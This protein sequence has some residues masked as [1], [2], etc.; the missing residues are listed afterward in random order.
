[1]DMTIAPSRILVPVDFSA[2]SAAALKMAYR[3]A[4]RFGA[5]IH[6][7]NATVVPPVVE[8]G[9]AVK[10]A[11]HR[12]STTLQALA[13]SS[14]REDLAALMKAH[15]AP[16]GIE[17]THEVQYGLPLEVI[18]FHARQHDLVVVGTHG[19]TGL[20]HLF[21]G[22][23]AERVVRHIDRPVIVARTSTNGIRQVL[24]AVDF[25]N[26]SRAAFVFGR[27]LAQRFGAEAR[28]VHVVPSIPALERAELMVVGAGDEPMVALHDYARWRAHEELQHFLSSMTGC[29]D[30]A[31]EVRF[32]DPALEIIEAAQTTAA[33]IVV[34]G[35]HGHTNWAWV[36][37]G[38]VAE[39]VVRQAPCSVLTTRW[40][41]AEDD[42]RTAKRRPAVVSSSVCG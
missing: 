3:V 11:T 34:M 8:P 10:L 20:D 32:G 13:L 38:S 16:D 27:R 23:V 6:V 21:V 41:A 30:V 12:S 19:R 39:R 22:S 4:G 15:P 14:A 25:S 9:L 37:V 29:R 36:G 35:T 24:I 5:R 26:A 31:I 18:E 28:L 17:V 1:M 7:V 33:D 42:D 40:A 2:S